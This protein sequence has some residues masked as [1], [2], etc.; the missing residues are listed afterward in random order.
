MAL[1]KSGGMEHAQRRRRQLNLAAWLLLVVVA[2]GGAFLGWRSYL[3]VWPSIAIGWCVAERN[4]LQSRM[5][6]WPVVRSYIDWQMVERDH[7]AQS[8]AT[9][10]G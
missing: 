2:V 5:A 6:M 8:M 10:N 9:A 3:T 7:Q 4:A 1:E